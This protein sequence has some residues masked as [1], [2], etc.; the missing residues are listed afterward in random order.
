M[1]KYRN[2]LPQLS[3]N[4]FITDGGLETTLVFE[5]RYDLPAFAAFDLLQRE[6]GEQALK[7]YFLP[8]IQVA[9]DNRLGFVLE[10]PTWRA[11]RDW[12][13]RIGY[14]SNALDTMNRRS[15]E[16]LEQIRQQHETATTPMVISGCI[17]PRSDG[18]AVTEKM[19]ADQ[20]QRYHREQI[21]TFS[22]TDAD[23]VTAFTLNYCEEAIGITRAAQSMVMPVVIGF[24]VEIDGRL[25]SGQSLGD[26]ITAV[27]R[28]TANGPAY[29]M[30]NCA[31]PTHF[32]QTLAVV[33]PWVERIRAV[34]ANASSKSHA[35]LYAAEALDD[36]DPHD[37]AQQ[38]ARL[39]TVLPHLTVVGGCCGT[40]HRH[41]DAICR[42]LMVH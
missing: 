38:Y 20:A 26:A 2:H 42:S 17:G 33:A 3:D 5:K 36:G 24:T 40:D 15:I 10:S 37:L 34:R 18:Y 19:T 39:Q 22:Q 11:S 7:D 14:D 21:E 29:Y 35:E 4:A 25:P 30:I 12:G 16:M 31:H 23:L 1:N 9:K 13:R 27:D 32:A 41:V 28:A 6:G 8:Y